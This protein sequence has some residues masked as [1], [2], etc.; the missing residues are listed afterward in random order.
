MR[1][2]LRGVLFGGGA[3]LLAAGTAY[4]AATDAADAGWEPLITVFGS[5]DKAK[6]L[7]QISAVNNAFGVTIRN[8]KRE[9]AVQEFM[10]ATIEDLADF[11]LSDFHERLPHTNGDYRE[12]WVRGD[13]K[14]DAYMITQAKEKKGYQVTLKG[15][16]NELAALSMTVRAKPTKGVGDRN[17]YFIGMRTGLGIGAVHWGDVMT[18]IQDLARIGATANPQKGATSPIAASAESK[19]AIKKLHPKLSEQDLE[20]LAV[21]W[22][23]YPG[24][25]T[26]LSKLGT[27]EDIRTVWQGK[28]YQQMSVLLR[29]SP[30]RL[31]KSSPAFAKYMDKMDDIALFDVKWLDKQGRT[32]TSMKI[33]SEKL[34][35]QFSCYVKD[36][37]LLPF[38]GV[39]VYEDEPVDPMAHQL[40]ATKVAVEA[41]VKLLGV[42]I[43]IKD[44][45]LDLFYEPTPDS[46]E[47]GLTLTKV[48]DDIKVDGAALG[49]VPTTM[50]DAFIP[51]D[52]VGIA[53]D[54]ITVAAKG[55]SGKGM[56]LAGKIGVGKAGSDRGVLEAGVDLDAL[57]NFLIKIGLGMV[58]ERLVPKPEAIDE[59]KAYAGAVQTAFAKDFDRYAKR[60]AR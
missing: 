35:F 16:R 13:L 19:A 37:Y 2:N 44:L 11:D 26:E 36:G 22:D 14:G 56:I 49:F 31:G 30:E 6:A 40:I 53:R 48:P 38:K 46:T 55:N 34:T 15:D 12:L 33:D 42:I 18:S 54:F 43:K 8:T 17:A 1:W 10:D 20:V 32:L 3:A 21:L 27:V 24:T 41:R 47:I 28:G 58:N 4:A 51:G 9:P 52:I 5:G 29:G 25:A 23:A 57:D 39:K 60:A 45:K 7:K 50:V 59:L